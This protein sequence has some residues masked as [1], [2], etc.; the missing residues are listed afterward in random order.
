MVGVAVRLS[1]ESNELC[2]GDLAN[3]ETEAFAVAVMPAS[4]LSSRDVGVKSGGSPNKAGCSKG[5]GV[6]LLEIMTGIE[7]ES[8]AVPAT[9]SISTSSS[10][11]GVK[12]GGSPNKPGCSDG[13]GVGLPRTKTGIWSSGG[14]LPENMVD[15]L[16]P[17]AKELVIRIM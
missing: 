15:R 16:F 10:D 9:L 8:V 2:L 13:S 12:S 5:S 17:T 6:G 3:E 7:T 1:L 4:S 14:E 11:V